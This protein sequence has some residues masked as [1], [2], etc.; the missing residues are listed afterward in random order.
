MKF[1]GEQLELKIWN[2]Q[3]ME[4]IYTYETEW[5]HQLCECSR[6]GSQVSAVESTSGEYIGADKELCLIVFAHLKKWTSSQLRL[7]AADKSPNPEMSLRK[8]NELYALF[9]QTQKC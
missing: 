6:R 9:Q 8:I 1:K 3:V 5:D 7:S 4:G 2:L